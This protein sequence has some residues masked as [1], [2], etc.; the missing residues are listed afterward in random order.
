M[1]IEMLLNNDIQKENIQMILH[2]QKEISAI[3]YI[4]E[5]KFKLNFNNFIWT[6]RNKI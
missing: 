2:F 5:K 4:R 3:M 1:V 6:N